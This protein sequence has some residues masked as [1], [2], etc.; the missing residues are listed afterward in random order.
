MPELSPHLQR[1]DAELVAAALSGPA[2]PASVTSC[3]AWARQPLGDLADLV[4]HAARLLPGRVGL[5]RRPTP[6]GKPRTPRARQRAPGR[7]RRPAT[8]AASSIRPG[9]RSSSAARRASPRRRG[10]RP[11]RRRG[12]CGP[13][14]RLARSQGPTARP[15]RPGSPAT[16]SSCASSTTTTSYSGIIGTPSIASIA[17]REW[18]VTISCDF[19]ACS[20]ARSAKHST[21]YGHLL[22]PRHSRWLTE[23]CA[24]DPVGVRR[25]A[26]AVTDAAGRRTPP[27]PTRA[28]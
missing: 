27:R 17:S 21:A 12:S 2:R 28:A 11:L 25:R 20:R 18:L 26:V 9:S 16:T 8:P 7:V 13:V 3:S 15:S 22:A 14:E 24:P 23:T 4:D 1:R 5:G 6:S 19:I 10:R